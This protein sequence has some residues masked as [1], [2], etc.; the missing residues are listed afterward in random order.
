MCPSDSIVSCCS[1]SFLF[2]RSHCFFYGCFS[3]LC[4]EKWTSTINIDDGESTQKYS[5]VS[6]APLHSN[7]DFLL[8]SPI[9]FR[10]DERKYQKKRKKTR[11]NESFA[12]FVSSP[13]F[14]CRSPS[15][16]ILMNESI[17][18]D[19]CN[20]WVVSYCCLTLSLPL[21]VSWLSPIDSPTET[22]RWQLLRARR[23]MTKISF[24]PRH[25]FDAVR[26]VPW[27]SMAVHRPAM[28]SSSTISVPRNS[29]ISPDGTSNGKRIRN[30]FFATHFPIDSLFPRRQ[31][32]N[33]GRAQP[34]RSRRQQRAKNNKHFSLSKRLYWLG[35]MLGSGV[36]HDFSTR[37]AV[38]ERFFSIEH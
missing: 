27:C 32:L 22:F 37:L 23:R 16:S 14:Q 7:C 8:S 6:V 12:F 24:I 18:L 20:A 36:L 35:I 17:K 29:T 1:F 5:R 9:K 33:Y 25:S 15:L 10:R 38:K 2:V 4:K 3:S 21:D 11:L 28:W 26:K 19:H 34:H 13:R 31:Q 30:P